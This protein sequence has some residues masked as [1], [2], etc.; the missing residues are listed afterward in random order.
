MCIIIDHCTGR[1]LVCLPKDNAEGFCREMKVHAWIIGN[2]VSGND[3][4]IYMSKSTYTHVHLHVSVYISLYVS[5][6]FYCYGYS[7]PYLHAGL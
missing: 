1:L 2:V 4:T 5:V 3:N 6:Y 7:H